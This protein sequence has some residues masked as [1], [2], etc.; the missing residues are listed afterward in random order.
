MGFATNDDFF[1]CHDFL[2][3]VLGGRS[4]AVWDFANS[5]VNSGLE[6]LPFILRN[7]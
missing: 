6:I 1:W 5:P 2:D 4:I 3:V 7:E